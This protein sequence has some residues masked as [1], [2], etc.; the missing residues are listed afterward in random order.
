[1]FHCKYVI[2]VL[3][4]NIKKYVFKD[5]TIRKQ[6]WRM[7]CVYVLRTVLIPCSIYINPDSIYITLPQQLNPPR[8][9]LSSTSSS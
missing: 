3:N 4:K 8:G 1:M 6:R 9:L 7:M 2:L 5:C